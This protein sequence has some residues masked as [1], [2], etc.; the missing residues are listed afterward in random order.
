MLS[1]VMFAA[2]FLGGSFKKR[3]QL[4][5]CS[6]VPDICRRPVP[7]PVPTHVKE[8][9]CSHQIILQPVEAKA[10][11]MQKVQRAKESMELIAQYMIGS[12]TILA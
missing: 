12:D 8:Y 9:E 10:E 3:D 2:F 5:E 11:E 1:F 6:S 7:L 4:C